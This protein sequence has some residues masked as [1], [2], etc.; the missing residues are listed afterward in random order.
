MFIS[1]TAKKSI[2]SLMGLKFFKLLELQTMSIH[3]KFSENHIKNIFFPSVKTVEQY[4]GSLVSSFSN[5]LR[6]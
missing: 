4:S 5:W 3:F 1:E 6:I 2:E